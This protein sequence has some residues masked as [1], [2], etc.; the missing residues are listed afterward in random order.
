MKQWFITDDANE[1]LR[2][3]LPRSPRMDEVIWYFDK[4]G[5]YSVKSGHQLAF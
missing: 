5:L 2:I 4:K 3:P 1:I